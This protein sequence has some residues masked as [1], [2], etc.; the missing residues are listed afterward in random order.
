MHTL[1]VY[2]M[3]LMWYCNNLYN[4][5]A[6]TTEKDKSDLAIQMHLEKI[7]PLNISIYLSFN[8]I[9]IY[10]KSLL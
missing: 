3:S 8:N 1:L 5:T 9:N 7:I 2:N 4:T 10:Y 6:K